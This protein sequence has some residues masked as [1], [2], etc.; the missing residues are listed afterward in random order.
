LPRPGDSE[1]TFGN[2]RIKPPPV[3]YLSKH[4]STSTSPPLKQR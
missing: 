4:S 1:V 3:Y 2:L